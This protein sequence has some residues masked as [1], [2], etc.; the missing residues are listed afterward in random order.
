MWAPAQ[1][2]AGMSAG[3]QFAGSTQTFIDI[4]APAYFHLKLNPRA[5]FLDLLFPQRQLS[6]QLSKSPIVSIFLALKV[7]V[8][9]RL[10]SLDPLLIARY[11]NFKATNPLQN[12]RRDGHC[13]ACHRWRDRGRNCSA[14][15]ASLAVNFAHVMFHHPHADLQSDGDFFVSQP[16]RDLNSDLL[17]SR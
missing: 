4:R 9:S 6:I 16:T 10:G 1:E 11:E 5:K 14:V 3:V 17:L 15:R 7:S 13:S 2:L 12:V 8:A